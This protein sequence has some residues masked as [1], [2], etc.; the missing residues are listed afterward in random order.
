MDA[1]EQG[2]QILKHEHEDLPTIKAIYHLYEML[3]KVY[4]EK[5]GGF[6]KAPKFPQP[7]ENN[8]FI[9]VFALSVKDTRVSSYS[10][11]LFCC[12]RQGRAEK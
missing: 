10:R 11:L 5:Y 9:T 1:L 12:L 7:G 2:T 6:G 8:M 4:D 3:E